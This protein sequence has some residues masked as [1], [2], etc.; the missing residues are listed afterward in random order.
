M[1]ADKGFLSYS[2]ALDIA[3]EKAA[4]ATY[5]ACARA[6]SSVMGDAFYWIV[7]RKNVELSRIFAD[8]GADNM[9][10]V[11]SVFPMMVEFQINA[12]S[13]DIDRMKVFV[14]HVRKINESVLP[15][16]GK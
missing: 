4:K 16:K 12:G 2:S 11:G 13:Q 15:K 3:F 10:Y 9:Y 5:P 7:V 8:V 6:S 14:A 1:A